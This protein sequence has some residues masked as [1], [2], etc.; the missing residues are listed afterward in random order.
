MKSF[1]P[2]A[3]II[4]ISGG[5]TANVPENRYIEPHSILVTKEELGK[6]WPLT[7]EKIEVG[8]VGDK[9]MPAYI[10]EYDNP[11][12]GHREIYALNGMAI[13]DG[14][15]DLFDS[16]IWSQNPK[17]KQLKMPLEP[18]CHQAH[19]TCGTAAF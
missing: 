17:A 8:C 13:R 3:A 18:L 7:V 1:V 10:L 11:K 6:R 4:L 16:G 15:K 5:C 9:K 14:Y 12:T 19:S 2:L